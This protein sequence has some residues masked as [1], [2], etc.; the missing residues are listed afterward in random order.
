MLPSLFKSS[1]RSASQLIPNFT[2]RST[3]HL[4]RTPLPLRSFT[5]T[6]FKMSKEDAPPTAFPSW[7]ISAQDQSGG[8]GLDKDMKQQA[9]WS[10]LEYWGDDGKPYLKEYEGRGLLKDKAVLITGGD[11]GIGRA[12]AILMARE[13]A[14]VSIVY[15]PE[16]EE[17]AKFT[18]GQIEKAGRKGH[19]M[20]LNLREE[21]NCKK[22]VEEHVKVFG[23]LNVLVNNGSSD[24]HTLPSISHSISNTH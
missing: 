13:G 15:L 3:Q 22:A 11:S 5:T 12:V 7:E 17:D 6:V 20:Q 23:K 21:E 24:P 1:F 8:P 16:E 4:S 9:V 10:Q 14:D 18:I 19:G 2:S